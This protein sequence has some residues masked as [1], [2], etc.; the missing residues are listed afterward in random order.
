MRKLSLS[1]CGGCDCRLCLRVVYAH[2]TGGSDGHLSVVRVL[3]RR[4]GTAAAARTAASSPARNA[5]RRSAALED[6]ATSIR[7]GKIRRRVQRAR[8]DGDAR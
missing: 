8:E 5:W 4:E 1:R 2:A 6:S 7:G 3:R